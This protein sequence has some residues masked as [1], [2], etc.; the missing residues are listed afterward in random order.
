MTDACRTPCRTQVVAAGRRV[1]TLVHHTDLLATLAEILRVPLP[2]DAA[3]D[4]F[5]M[6]RLLLGDDATPVRPH[7]V[8]C[9]MR[10]VPTLRVG[11]WKLILGRGSGGWTRAKDS[12]LP[13]ALYNLERDPE[14]RHDLALNESARVAKM[15]SLL[16][17]DI[18]GRGRSAPRHAPL[19]TTARQAEATTMKP[20]ACRRPGHCIE[21]RRGVI[22]SK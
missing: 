7:A 4:S 18:V 21:W 5:S 10:N 22:G 9:S 12:A 11:P 20:V 19:F 8:S 2:V 14:E 15:R 3:E 1:S 17:D 6:L 16:L 13:E